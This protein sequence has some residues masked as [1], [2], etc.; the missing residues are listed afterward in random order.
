MKVGDLVRTNGHPHRIGVVVGRTGSDR[1]GH[2]TVFFSD[3]ATMP[4]PC[5]M[6]VVWLE[7]IN[8]S[9]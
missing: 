4:N 9:W 8:E 7:V 2:V 1:N 6:P 3:A 5:N